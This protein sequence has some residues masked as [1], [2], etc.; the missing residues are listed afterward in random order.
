MYRGK[1][2]EMKKHFARVNEKFD[3]GIDGAEGK[4]TYEPT[5]KYTHVIR[6]FS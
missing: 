4:W 1:I 5:K 6:Y 3:I 2:E